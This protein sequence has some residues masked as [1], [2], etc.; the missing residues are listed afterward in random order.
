MGISGY[1]VFDRMIFQIPLIRIKSCSHGKWGGGINVNYSHGFRT[2]LEVIKIT[3]LFSQSIA[4]IVLVSIH[5]QSYLVSTD[6]VLWPN[7]L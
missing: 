4:N 5:L 2:S 1:L 6:Q 7:T 3:N